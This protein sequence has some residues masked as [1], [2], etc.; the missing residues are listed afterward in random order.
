[1]NKVDQLLWNIGAVVVNNESPTRKF[2]IES[3][4]DK[5]VTILVKENE[6]VKTFVIK[7]FKDI[8]AFNKFFK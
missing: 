5:Q 8:K 2:M 7:T 6:V 1:M 4:D 3:M